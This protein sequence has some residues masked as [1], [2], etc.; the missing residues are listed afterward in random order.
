MSEARVTKYL[1]SQREFLDDVQSLQ[2]DLFTLKLVLCHVLQQ[3]VGKVRIQAFLGMHEST[4]QQLVDRFPDLEI[5]FNERLI[6]HKGGD[7]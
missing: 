5:T 1:N 4:A 6:S 7:V 2:S 3:T